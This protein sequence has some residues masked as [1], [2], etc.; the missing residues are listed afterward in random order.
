MGGRIATAVLLLSTRSRMLARGRAATT[1]RRD[2]GASSIAA[3]MHEFMMQVFRCA[4]Y[5]NRPFSARMGLINL[6]LLS[7]CPKWHSSSVLQQCE[8]IV[9]WKVLCTISFFGNHG[10]K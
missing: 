4:K 8:S 3:A 10:I 1:R 9:S 6:R 2:E 7:N 5:E